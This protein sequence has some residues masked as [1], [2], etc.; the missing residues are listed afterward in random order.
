ME[1]ILLT[2]YKSPFPKM[3]IGR[4]ADGGY[5]IAVIP[6][7]TYD[8]LLAG[9]V[10]DDISFEEHFLHVHNQTKCIA[11]DGT[12][13]QLPNINERIM[14][15]KKNIGDNNSEGLTNL[16]DIIDSYKSIFVK[17]DIEG[18]EIN[19][20]KCLTDDHLNKFD[21]IVM[22]FHYP[23][24][25]NDNQ[26]FRI[27]NKNHTLIHFHGNNNCGLR[28]ID[29][30]NI[31][32]VFECTYIHNRFITKLELNNESIPTIFDRPNLNHNTEI[33]LNYAPFVFKF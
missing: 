9:G 25:E 30:I 15:I 26:A 20:L 3:R 12:V 13:N 23:F 18:A 32:N 33:F 5:V 14:F 31:P 7:N 24:T 21:Q 17:M 11:L 8:L 28:N 29:G 1:P 6:N 27:L 19:W 4:D 16:H 2:V 10:A 22:E